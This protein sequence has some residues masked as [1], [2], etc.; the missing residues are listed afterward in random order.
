MQEY[1]DPKPT[2]SDMAL[3][4]AQ[5]R[6][7][8]AVEQDVADARSM[9]HA[10]RMLFGIDGLQLTGLWIAGFHFTGL[11][12]PA[13]F[14]SGS[15]LGVNRRGVQLGR[16]SADLGHLHVMEDRRGVEEDRGQVVF[17]ALALLVLH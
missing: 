15:D 13:G 12:S 5:G 9:E 14:A 1:G 16:Q 4:P 3:I 2:H 7:P 11:L 17:V 8:M 10:R 6:D